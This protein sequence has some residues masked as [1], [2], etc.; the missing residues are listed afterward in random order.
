MLHVPYKGSG[1][2]IIDLVGGHVHVAFD[3]M[4]T[5]HAQAKIGKLRA[6]AVTG[7]QRSPIVPEL[8]TVGETVPGFQ[9]TSWQGFFAPAGTPAI[10]L[11]RL[12]GEIRGIMRQPD[13]ATR[14]LDIGVTPVGSGRSEFSAFVREETVR[15]AEVVKA[16]GARTDD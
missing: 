16:S 2:M 7:A 1:P 14:M 9:V 5:A 3:N 11:D 10:I 4:P 15:W 12:S 13:V 6:I 8:P